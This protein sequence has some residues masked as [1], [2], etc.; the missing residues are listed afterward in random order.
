MDFG[1]SETQR[2][3]QQLARKILSEQVSPDRL[4][5]YD[6]FAAPRFDRELWQQ[7]AD[8]G[9]LGVALGETHGGMGLGFFELALVVEEAGRTLAPVP[10]V[11]HCISGALAVDRFGSEAQKAALLPGAAA[12]SGLLTAA[13]VEPANENP[14]APR[15]TTATAEGDGY[16]VTGVKTCVPFGREATRILLAATAE[17]GVV[18]LLLDPSA[19][20]VSMTDTRY[21]TYEPQVELELESVA[22]GAADVLAGPGQ[23]ADVMRW[24]AER[25]SAALCAHQLGVS[26]AAMR[27][28]ASYTAEREQFGVPIATFQAVGHRAANCFIDV[29]CLRL[30]TYQAL[31]LLDAGA[32]A[33]TAVQIA[34]VWAGDVGHRVSYAAQHL[35][36]GTGIDRDYP[37]WRFC[38]WAR[39][40]ETM[41]GGSARQLA[42][43]GARIAR[44][45]A[46]CS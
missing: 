21:T 43:L 37:L 22:I 44:G 17:D 12:G 9:L 6:E 23:G 4:S 33:T 16:R 26:D 41:L 30:N 18:L 42:A 34:K 8:A 2:D 38:L 40:N 39:H 20:G 24:I 32:E 3:V 27:M 29:E 36:G 13:L 5:Q 10:L 14:A 28:T 45:E 7:L 35:H 19:A 1:L 11:S 15:A 46:R 25:T 31:S